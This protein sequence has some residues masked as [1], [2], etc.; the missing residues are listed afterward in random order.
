MLALLAALPVVIAA[1]GDDDG[2]ATAPAASTRSGAAVEAPSGADAAPFAEAFAGAT[3]LDGSVF[4]PVRLAG[5]D[6]VIWFWAPWCTIC[7]GEAAD[8]AA[9]ARRRAGEVTFV[10]V[11]GRD[12]LDA[13]REFVDETGTG[14]FT[15]VADLDG[16]VWSAF[17]VYGQPAYAFVDDTGGIEV[18]VGGLGG[19]A[20]AERIDELLAT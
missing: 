1:C 2:A 5:T 4:D 14:S 13:M 20:L 15:H 9:L 18:F 3:T 12:E 17:G 7:R 8:V 6:A 16:S 19:D 11:A 10:G